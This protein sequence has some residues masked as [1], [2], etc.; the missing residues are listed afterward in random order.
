[1]Y[2]SDSIVKVA[3]LIWC[4]SIPTFWSCVEK[5]IFT[6]EP[7]YKGHLGTNGMVLKWKSS[8]IYRCIQILY[9]TKT[10]IIMYEGVLYH[11]LYCT[12]FVYVYNK[13]TYKYLMTLLQC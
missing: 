13:Y 7:L 1:M 9:S 10:V 12:S 8:L 11:N 3:K 2:L 5:R 6:V 4:T